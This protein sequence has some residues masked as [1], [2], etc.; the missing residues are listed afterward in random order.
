MLTQVNQQ[1]K[2]ERPNKLAMALSLVEP[3]LA[4]GTKIGSLKAP[5]STS[6]KLSD[7]LHAGQSVSNPYGKKLSFGGK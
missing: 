6:T 4:I 5:V 7:Y 1:P 3:A 2:K